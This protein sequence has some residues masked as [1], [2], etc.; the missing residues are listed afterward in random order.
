[1]SKFVYTKKAR[2]TWY[3]GRRYDS[4]LEASW[5]AFFKAKGIVFEPQPALDLLAWR[6]DFQINLRSSNILAEVKPFSSLDQWRNNDEI[7]KIAA[8]FQDGFQVALLGLSPNAPTCFYY[9][10]FP[11]DPYFEPEGGDMTEDFEEIDFGDPQDVMR[12]WNQ[13]RTETEW[14]WGK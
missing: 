13:A 12:K 10:Q 2:S 6:P 14:K 11:P 5:A 4:E 1:M 7:K 8:S 9:G 3:D